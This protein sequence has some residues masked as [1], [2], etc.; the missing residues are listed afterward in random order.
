MK[1]DLQVN[2]KKVVIDESTYTITLDKESFLLF[3]GGIGNTS[4]WSR[5][6][7]GMTKEQAAFFTGLYDKLHDAYD[8]ASRTTCLISKAAP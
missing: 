1:F 5:A 2:E 7:A 3:S 6:K 4:A 8:D